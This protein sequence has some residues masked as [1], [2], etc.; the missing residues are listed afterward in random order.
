MILK[1][2]SDWL[3]NP[4]VHVI[5]YI[6]GQDFLKVSLIMWTYHYNVVFLEQIEHK[7]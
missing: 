6:T 5:I 3:V 7:H 1:V 2:K 4:L